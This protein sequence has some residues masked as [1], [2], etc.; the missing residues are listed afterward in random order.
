[1]T[2]NVTNETSLCFFDDIQMSRQGSKLF[3][4]FKMTKKLSYACSATYYNNFTQNITSV[5][6]TSDCSPG[7][8]IFV[9]FKNLQVSRLV[10]IVCF[11][12]FAI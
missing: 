7:S 2:A 6:A 1:M 11:K 10:Y 5:N 4:P 3:Y 9:I 12:L 8:M